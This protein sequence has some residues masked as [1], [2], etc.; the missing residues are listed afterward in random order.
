MSEEYSFLRG[1]PLYGPQWTACFPKGMDNC[2]FLFGTV[3]ISHCVI[4]SQRL[5]DSWLAQGNPT[6]SRKYS[7]LELNIDSFVEKVALRL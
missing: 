5:M 1:N 2:T 6:L 7:H 4:R 3:Q